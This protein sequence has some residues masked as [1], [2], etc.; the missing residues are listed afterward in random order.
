MLQVEVVNHIASELPVELLER[1]VRQ[2]LQQRNVLRAEISVAIVDDPTIHGLNQQY[3][4]HDY[5]TDV[6]TFPLE[7]PEENGRLVGDVIVSWD[8]AVANAEELDLQPEGELLLYVIHGTLHL[9]GL[10]D[11]S[12]ELAAEMRA[13]ERSCLES[14]GFPYRY[15]DQDSVP[16]QG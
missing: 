12:E 10:D 3:L 14:L 13:A 9:L 15:G 2:L 1:A 5:P 11:T 7:T 6:L 4:S 8:T 16:P